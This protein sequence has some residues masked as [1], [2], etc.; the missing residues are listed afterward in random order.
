MNE[1][2]KAIVQQALDILERDL[3]VKGA[4]LT[5]PQSVRNLLRLKLEGLEAEVFA[6]LFLDN[7]H[8]L[9]EYRAMFYG[10]ID[11]ASVYPREVV[12]AALYN[13]AAACILAHNHPSGISEPSQSD[14]ALTR[15]LKEALA[16]V[17][18]RVLDHLVVGQREITSFAERG[19][20]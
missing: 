6:V 14:L 15:K 5:S 10:T 8:R 7:Q 17:D 4:A 18:I 13:N 9:I 19:L 16:L 3:K 1:G 12:K 2:E 11:S 20:L